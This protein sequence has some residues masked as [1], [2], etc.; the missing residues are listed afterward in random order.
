[1]WY[2][3]ETDPDSLAYREASQGWLKTGHL[4]EMEGWVGLYSEGR[5]G[6]RQWE[7]TDLGGTLKL[8]SRNWVSHVATMRFHLCGGT[9]DEQNFLLLLWSTQEA[10]GPPCG[11]DKLRICM[12]P[13]SL[14]FLRLS[15]LLIQQMPP[16]HFTICQALC[17]ALP[18]TLEQFGS[19]KCV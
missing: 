14:V 16:E 5:H 2:R 15:G 12:H 9:V 18:Q 10:Q 11:P 8:W 3:G 7:E 17:L 4:S 19:S 13:S 1:M 6:W